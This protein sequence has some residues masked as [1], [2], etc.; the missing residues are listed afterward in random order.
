MREVVLDTETTGLSPKDG[1]R[2][3]EIGCVEL[4]NHVPTGR[5]WQRYINP[6]RSMPPE[7]LRVHG[8]TEEFLQGYPVFGEVARAFLEFIGDSR[9]VIH[10]AEFDLS[11]LNSELERMGESLIP[12]SRSI[13]TTVMAR[14]KFPGAPASLEALCRRFEIDDS[15]REKHGALL[16]AQLL[17][18]VYL[19]L[20]GGRQT[21]F[22]LS[23]EKS[24]GPR[25]LQSKTKPVLRPPRKHQPTAEECAAHEAFINTLVDPL[26]LRYLDKTGD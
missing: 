15:S 13:D 4:S 2:L 10:N 6:K 8:L 20:Q 18:E 24:T 5:T 23:V 9:L 11:F 12:L 17:S 1:H 3:V 26:W 14:K 19:E 16:D 7:A 22:I 25:P 21:S